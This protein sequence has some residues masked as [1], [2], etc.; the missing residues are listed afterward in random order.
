[1]ANEAGTARH[2]HEF[3][4]ESDQTARRDAILESHAALRVNHHIRELCAA[5]AQRFHDRALALGIDIH[6]QRLERLKRPPADD[7]IEQL[8]LA[9][10]ELEALAAAVLHP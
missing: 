6:R 1:M 9:G 2:G 5:C 8:L 7:L 4:L 3:P 10:R